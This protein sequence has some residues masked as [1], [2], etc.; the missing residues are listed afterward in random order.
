MSPRIIELGRWRIC[1][2]DKQTPELAAFLILARCMQIQPYR[3]FQFIE[4]QERTMENSLY[5]ALSRQVALSENMTIIANNIANIN[6]PGFR[7][8]NMI[9]DEYLADPKGLEDPLSMVLDYGHYQNTD[10]GPV[11]LTGGTLDVALQG[12][13][14]MGI[15]A[16]DGSTQYTR[17][18]NFTTDQNGVLKNALGYS[19]ADV[20]GGEIIIPPQ[21]KD[22][23][24]DENGFISTDQ[25][26][27]G[28]LM[29]IEFDNEQRLDPQGNGLYKTDEGGRPAE[30]TRVKQGMLEGSNVQ[31]VVEMTRMIDVSREYQAIARMVQNEHDRQRTAIQR[32][33]QTQG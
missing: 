13:G 9:F 27:A 15:L 28:R 20:G 19:V 5:V 10:E 16:A 8:Q 3:W 18:G 2:Y 11:S 23:R 1:G 32:I 33:L 12:P 26:E 14:F 30:M 17:A 25:G 6:T 29:I 7:A 4:K 21:V 31:G 22:I 24:I